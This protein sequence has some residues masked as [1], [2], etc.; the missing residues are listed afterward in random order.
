MPNAIPAINHQSAGFCGST[1]PGADRISS[2]NRLSE[3]PAE[4]VATLA[5]ALIAVS[6][7]TSTLMPKPKLIGADSESNIAG[8]WLGSTAAGELAISAARITTDAAVIARFDGRSRNQIQP[9][10]SVNTG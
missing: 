2:G 6:L 8:I 1:V 5:I 3:A 9:I 4:N 7:C 10:K